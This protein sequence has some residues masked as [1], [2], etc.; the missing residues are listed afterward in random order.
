MDQST[1]YHNKHG[2]ITA[3]NMENGVV[4]C[5]LTLSHR[6]TKPVCLM[7]VYDLIRNKL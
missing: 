4:T 3:F 6:L 5:A 2:I 7:L 1:T